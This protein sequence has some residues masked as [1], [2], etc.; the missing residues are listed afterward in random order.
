[1][2]HQTS[3][4]TLTGRLVVL[5]RQGDSFSTVTK[6]GRWAGRKKLRKATLLARWGERGLDEGEIHSHRAGNNCILL[7]QGFLSCSCAFP[8]L[9]RRKAP[10]SAGLFSAVP[11]LPRRVD[12]TA[13]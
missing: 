4:A 5:A 3:T 9:V 8:A 6:R 11:A 10:N 1:M 2:E 7:K 12:G 13:W